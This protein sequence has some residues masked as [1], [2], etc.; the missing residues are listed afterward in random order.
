MSSEKLL[1]K[2]VI[3]PLGLSWTFPCSL[4]FISFIPLFVYIKEHWLLDEHFIIFF[5]YSESLLFPYCKPMHN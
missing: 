3:L 1:Q 2:R 5:F 4:G